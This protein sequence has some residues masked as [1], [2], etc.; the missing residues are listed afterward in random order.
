MEKTL[1]FT[2][3]ILCL[4]PV[5]ILTGP[6]LSDSIVTIIALVFLFCTFKYRNWHY[7]HN[8]FFYYFI[9][10]YLYI[11]IRSLFSDQVLISLESSLFYFRFIFFALGVW[12]ILDH[13]R[14]FLYLF[15]YAVFFA[16]FVCII[17][18]YYQYF[19][20]INSDDGIGQN[21]FGYV[22]VHSRLTLLLSNEL[23]LG[24]YLSRLFPLLIALLILLFPKN[25]LFILFSLIMMVLID[26]LVFLSGERTALALMILSTILIVGLVSKLRLLRIIAIIL[27]FLSIIL[28]SIYDEDVKER[29]LNKT[30][31]QLNLDGS[32]DEEV[33]FSTEHDS[34]MK[35][36]IDIF[37]ENPIFGIGP[38]LFRFECQNIDGGVGCST[39]PH[40]SY[41][42]LLAETGIIGFM[43]MIVL[44]IIVTYHFIKHFYL[45]QTK[46]KTILTD[47][48]ICLLICFY[49]TL[50]PI[51]PTVNLFNNWINV[52]YF[53]PI[54]FFLHS[55]KLD[56]E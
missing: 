53:L 55:F 10:F 42:Q 40:N 16:F 26:L 49:L 11:L 47:Y 14:N 41:I 19:S 43:F 56:K 8:S 36:A 3:Y 35:T 23:V 7:L 33:F 15:T 5:A 20:R 30:I 51:V 13:K 9:I 54:G 2:G 28:I 50:W 48:Q 25:K 18:G 31:Q 45:M 27:S 34:I 29:N 52:I 32:S 46:Q 24:S 21:L 12:F 17:D 4:L 1:N 22:G 37:Q 44:L 39:H 38:K 6:F